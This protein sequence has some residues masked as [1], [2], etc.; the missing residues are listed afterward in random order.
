M[1]RKARGSAILAGDGC[2]ADGGDG[3]R[4][5]DHGKGECQSEN[6][7]LHRRLLV[8]AAG[9][10]GEDRRAADGGNSDG[11]ADHGE[12]ERQSERELFQ[13]RLPWFSRSCRRRRQACC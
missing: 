6:E 9:G 2:A 1:P 8:S 13:G 5:T 4:A 3:D 12:G 11:T 7:L 10:A